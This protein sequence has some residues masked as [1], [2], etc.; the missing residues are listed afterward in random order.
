MKRTCLSF[1]ML[2]AACLFI[3]CGGES[4]ADGGSAGGDSGSSGPAKTEFEDK[5]IIHNL[6]DPEGLHP[7]NVSDASAT[8]T[9]RFIM[10]KL[11]F[12]D[13]ESLELQPWLASKLPELE[14]TDL[15]GGK[16]GMNITYEL[17][18]EAKWDDGTP[19]SPADVEFSFKSII[20]P[21]T[22]AAT[23]RPYLDYIIDFKTYPDNPQKFTF[24]CDDTYMLW[25]H[26]TGNDVWI[27]QKKI[28]D[29]NGLS[30]KFSIPDFRKKGSKVAEDSDN[31]KFAEN[32]NSIKYHREKGF[33]AGSGPYTFDSWTTG[34]R[35]ILKRKAD[36][37]GS[38]VKDGGMMF[39][40]GP[41][42]IMYETINDMTTALTALKAGKLDIMTSLR[43]KQWVDDVEKSKKFKANFNKSAPPFPY[44][45]YIGMD[46]RQP[47]F[48]GKKTR[49]ALAH[50]VDAD[51][52]N[53]TLL[54][55]QH[56]RI[57]GPISK[58]DKAYHN[59]L[60]PYAFDVE[61]AKKL[62]EE[63][64]WS[65]TDGNGIIDKVIDGVKQDFKVEFSF[66]QGNDTRKKVGLAMK[67]TF[68]Q[69]GIDMT[70][71]SVEWSVFLERLKKHDI[72]MWYGA[73]VFD[74]RPS[75]PK[76]I[77][78]TESYNGGSNYTGF[79]D[80]KSDKLIADIR[81]EMDNDKRDEL[82]K[83]WQELLYDECP[84]I[85]L[86]GANRRNA[87][88]KRFTEVNEGA[89]DPGYWAGGMTLAKGFSNSAN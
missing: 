11:L 32:Y 17:R 22:D 14:I 57:V 2:F 19:V 35:I 47:K 31:L 53:K 80:A 78:H 3:G 66:N 56:Y 51:G 7:S 33:V 38:A 8:E 30:D 79:G 37:W 49:Q 69:A 20:N 4:S 54:Y 36:W 15:G 48:S 23:L 71:A 74:T 89:R 40:D 50:L 24:V 81:K 88:H 72:E 62:L 45:S 63:D 59:G 27:I 85:F 82:Y 68:R 76:Q 1:L 13:F 70:V 16:K 75:D 61:K 39:Q 25:D 44:Y 52:I 9:K 21:K 12:I 6:S 77:W 41:K 26:V 5:V 46:N 67:E 73:W 84:Y 43:P 10:Q 60:K 83:Q 55:N 34:Q 28:Y 58:S 64:G 29:P 87:I 86:Y 42:E 65:D 18:K